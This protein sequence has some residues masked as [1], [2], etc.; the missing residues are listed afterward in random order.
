MTMAE[1]INNRIQQVRDRLLV[2]ERERNELLR[3]LGE[4]ERQAYLDAPPILGAPLP[5]V[6]LK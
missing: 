3:Q 4:L 2:V 6:V 1:G 5:A